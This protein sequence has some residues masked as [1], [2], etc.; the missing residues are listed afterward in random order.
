MDKDP[1]VYSIPQGYGTVTPWLISK[2][3]SKMI[4]FLE[5]AFDAKEIAG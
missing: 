2:D 4:E 1:L 3:S 5:K